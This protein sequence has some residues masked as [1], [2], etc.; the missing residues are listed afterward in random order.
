MLPDTINFERAW[1]FLRDAFVLGYFIG[2]VP[3]GLLLGRLFGIGDVR[4]R[5][6]GNIGAINMMRLGGLPLGVVTLLLDA[7]KGAAPV[8]WVVYG[9]QYGPLTATVAGFAAFVGHCFSVFLL[10]SGGKG[11]ATGFGFILAYSVAFSSDALPLW[12]IG[13]ICAGVWLAAA[14]TVR[15]ASVASLCAALAAAIL[16]PLYELWDAAWAVFAMGLITLYRHAG[17]IRRLVAG[18]EPR[19]SLGRGRS[20]A[21][22]DARSDTRTRPEPRS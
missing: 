21:E 20:G 7:A 10:F 13:P 15:I 2:A 11:V 19:I 4:R 17:N 6:S 18:T 1:P 3:F 5:G 9:W 8:L 22:G 16:F 12:P 14:L